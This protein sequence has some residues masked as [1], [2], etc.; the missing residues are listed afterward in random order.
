MSQTF[1]IG[2]SKPHNRT[3]AL[4]SYN[5]ASGVAV[6]VCGRR[7]TSV[8]NLDDPETRVNCK[9]CLKRMRNAPK[10]ILKLKPPTLWERLLEDSV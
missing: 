9:N 10:P 8:L 6:A 5:E 3:H 2:C 1:S 7:Y 4:R